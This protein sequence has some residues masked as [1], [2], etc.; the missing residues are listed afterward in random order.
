ME[1]FAQARFVKETTF[2]QVSDMATLCMACCCYSDDDLGM[3]NSCTLI[4]HA[5]FVHS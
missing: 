2:A 1:P 4:E 3:W 5:I